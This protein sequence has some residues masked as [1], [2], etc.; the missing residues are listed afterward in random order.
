MTGFEKRISG[1]R[2]NRSTN[3]STTIAL[4]LLTVETTTIKKKEAGNGHFF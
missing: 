2:S 1:M 4:L 3:C